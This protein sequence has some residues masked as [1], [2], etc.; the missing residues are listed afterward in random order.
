MASCLICR[1]LSGEV[2]VPGGI[3]HQEIASFVEQLRS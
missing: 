2:A 1:K 3:V